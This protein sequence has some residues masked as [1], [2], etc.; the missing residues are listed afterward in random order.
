VSD[1]PPPGYAPPPGYG[2][3]AGS[4]PY[5]GPPYG[6]PPPT[7]WQGAGYLPYGY[8]GDG[9][10][11]KIRPTG[12]SILLFFCTL[13]IYGFVYNYSVHD[14]MRRHSGRGIGGGIAL[15]LSFI[16]AIAMPF[17]T[18]AEVGSLYSRRGQQPPVS[19]WTG[20]FAVLPVMFGYFGQIV[21]A[22]VIFPFL[23]FSSSDG[24]SITLVAIFVVWLVVV[25][26]GGI[27]WFVK[28]NE[29]LNNYW[30]SV[31]VQKF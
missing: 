25:V 9:P 12:I 29:A 10:P 24:L 22:C 15:L 13:G 17:V 20:L 30:I 16:A 23:L 19:G 21:F 26:G 27:F 8:Y 2:P 6:G 18:A 3:P 1:T 28:T 5:G 4:P 7:G 14:E 11:G 31:G